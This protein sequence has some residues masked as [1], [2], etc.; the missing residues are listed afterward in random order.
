MQADRNV[1]V[2]LTE[3]A[4]GKSDC[5]L[6]WVDVAR[7]RLP[8]V[9]IVPVQEGVEAKD[10]SCPGSASA[11]TGGS[12]TE[13][14]ALAISECRDL[15]RLARAWPPTRTPDSSMSSGFDGRPARRAGFR[16]AGQPAP[17]PP[18][19]PAAAAPPPCRPGPAAA[20]AADGCA[21]SRPPVRR[22]QPL[23][24]AASA[25]RSCR[26][27]MALSA[28]ASAEATPAADVQHRIW[29]K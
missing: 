22:R 14:V 12:R 9:Q 26:R 21:P 11:R 8:R 28:H 17:A 5:P 25:S 1:T 6:Y 4:R 16:A 19:R 18:P 27:R 23:L 13:H 7:R 29:L 3:R 15:G 10:I 2:P 24:A 20:P